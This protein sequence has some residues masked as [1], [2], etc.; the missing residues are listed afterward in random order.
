[1]M[2]CQYEVRD[3]RDYNPSITKIA[4]II[5]KHLVNPSFIAGENLLKLVIFSFQIGLAECT[6]HSKGISL[7]HWLSPDEAPDQHRPPRPNVQQVKR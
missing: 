7:L 1:M 5:A 3:L 2:L 4:E 6:K